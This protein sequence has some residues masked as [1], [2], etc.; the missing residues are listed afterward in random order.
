[1]WCMISRA[2]LG[3]ILSSQQSGQGLTRSRGGECTNIS[4]SWNRGALQSRASSAHRMRDAVR[5]VELER[6]ALVVRCSGDDLHGG[7]VG[8]DKLG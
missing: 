6:R 7:S 4:I 8:W 3:I 1:M 2:R 5:D